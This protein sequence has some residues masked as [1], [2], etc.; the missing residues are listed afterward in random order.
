METAC[1]KIPKQEITYVIGGFED[2]QEVL[3][4]QNVEAVLSEGTGTVKG[5]KS[6]HFVQGRVW[7]SG[8][9]PKSSRKLTKG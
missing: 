6:R 4:D 5:A 2:N 1:S 8:L 3:G 9:W 7:D